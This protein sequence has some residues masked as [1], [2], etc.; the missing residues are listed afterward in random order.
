MKI[1]FPFEH[2]PTKPL[3]EMPF[4]AVCE[5]PGADR[6]YLVVA[7]IDMPDCRLLVSLDQGIFRRP[8]KSLAVVPVDA[9][10]HVRDAR[11]CRIPGEIDGKKAYCTL[12][13]GH[14]GAHGVE[15]PARARCGNRRP[16]AQT[17]K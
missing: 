11:L 4:G 2:A 1:I 7:A 16:T 6:L 10:L 9:E 14:A 17:R 15:V 3:A 5:I 12:H 8:E 13:E